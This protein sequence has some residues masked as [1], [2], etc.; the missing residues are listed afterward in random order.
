MH[1]LC[2]TVEAGDVKQAA[3]A[4]SLRHSATAHVKMS[5]WHRQVELTCQNRRISLTKQESAQ[6]VFVAEGGHAYFHVLAPLGI[7]QDAGRLGW[8][9]FHELPRHNYR[10]WLAEPIP[11]T[12]PF[13]IT[14]SDHASL[15]V[16]QDRRPDPTTLPCLALGSPI[17]SLVA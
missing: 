14:A 9:F 15:P 4:K 7:F 1:G 11:S 10:A 3:R 5:Y 2:H 6:R 12:T 17:S 8:M 13:E 16:T